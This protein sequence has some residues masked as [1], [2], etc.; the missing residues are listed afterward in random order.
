MPM[1]DHTLTE[2]GPQSY[3]LSHRI[4]V[5][6]GESEQLGHRLEVLTASGHYGQAS[7]LHA[8]EQQ[9][10]VEIVVLLR[11]DEDVCERALSLVKDVVRTSYAMRQACINMNDPYMS[12]V[13]GR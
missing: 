5:L 7:V 4:P 8:Q 1:Y 3:L 2:L 6:L 13:M 12:L 10:E 11:G 9:G